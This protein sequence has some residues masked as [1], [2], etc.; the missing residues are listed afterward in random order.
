M[1]KMQKFV[2]FALVPLMLLSLASCSFLAG[3]YSAAKEYTSV[4]VNGISFDVRSDMTPDNSLKNSEGIPV[5]SYVCDYYGVTVD[6]MPA[7][8]L[9]FN[10]VGDVKSVLAMAADQAGH[11]DDA[12]LITKNDVTTMV[13]DETIDGTLYH[14]RS[15]MKD[16]GDDYCIVRFF[17]ATD[18]E[19][20]Y[21]AEYQKIADS[22]KLADTPPA[23]K[24]ITVEGVTLTVD[25]GMTEGP[26]DNS[27]YTAD[28]AMLVMMQD[29]NVSAHQFTRAL[30]ASDDDPYVTE[31]GERVTEFTTLDDS[32]IDFF[33]SYHDDLYFY[34]Y[35]QAINRKVVYICFNT[36][37]A[38]DSAQLARFEEI[39]RS[40]A[41]AA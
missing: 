34:N 10:E 14:F 28:Y 27:F 25:S 26:E 29:V 2:A 4:T 35:I 7:G 16:L 20:S 19:N 6:T 9:K 12:Q 37:K 21:R 11:V 31:D 38:A 17:T 30:L 41:H 15:Y 24:E 1:L 13:Y 8:M 18:Y 32:Q 40:A 22:A 36:H 39:V 5:E 3:G 33:A 23:T